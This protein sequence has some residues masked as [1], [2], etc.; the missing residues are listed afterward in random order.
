MR[1]YLSAVRYCLNSAFLT[2]CQMMSTTSAFCMPL[3]HF[4]SSSTAWTIFLTNVLNVTALLFLYWRVSIVSLT[5]LTYCFC[6]EMF[7]IKPDNTVYILVKST[8]FKNRVTSESF[9]ILTSQVYSKQSITLQQKSRSFSIPPF[10]LHGNHACYN[11]IRL[12]KSPERYNQQELSLLF[13]HLSLP[14]LSQDQV[15]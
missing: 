2:F 13:S 3:P 8:R 1:L 10:L 11:E 15:Q 6:M 12:Q 4:S 7:S 9:L 5:S 14:N